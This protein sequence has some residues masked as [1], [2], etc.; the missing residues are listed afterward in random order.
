MNKINIDEAKIL[1]ECKH[2]VA[3]LKE[4]KEATSKMHEEPDESLLE[5]Y[6]QVFDALEALKDSCIENAIQI[7]ERVN[8]WNQKIVHDLVEEI[9]HYFSHVEKDLNILQEN[10]NKSQLSPKLS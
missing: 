6:L 4:I 9:T 2:L 8:W 10:L 3:H 7:S 1:L 5:S